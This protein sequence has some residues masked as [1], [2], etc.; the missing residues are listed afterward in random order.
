MRS[1]WDPE[2][3][4]FI[5]ISEGSLAALEAQLLVAAELRLL[6]PAESVSMLDD[7]HHFVECSISFIDPSSPPVSVLISGRPRLLT[8][9]P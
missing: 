9:D 2:L 5:R 1:T 3:R 7:V 4:R 6:A 8:L